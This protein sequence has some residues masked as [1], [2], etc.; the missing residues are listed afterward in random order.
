MN[1]SV[2]V[3]PKKVTCSPLQVDTKGSCSHLTLKNKINSKSANQIYG[4]LWELQAWWRAA[5]HILWKSLVT[6]SQSSYSY[7]NE[8]H[9]GTRL[10][11][12]QQ[13]CSKECSLL[14]FMGRGKW[15]CALHFLSYGIVKKMFCEFILIM[16][17]ENNMKIHHPHIYLHL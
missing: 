6:G 1:Y 3:N 2:F 14:L 8:A 11:G 7:D 16:R 12:N 13:N 15:S 9:T 4:G 5:V 10:P 17:E